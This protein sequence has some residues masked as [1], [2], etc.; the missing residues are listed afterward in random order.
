[1]TTTNK[2]SENTRRTLLKGL[3]ATSAV[4]AASPVLAGGGHVHHHIEKLNKPLIKIAN[5]CAQHGDECIDHC[6]ELFK[7]GDT[8]LAKCADAVNEMIVMCRALAKMA[9]YQSPE[10]KALAKICINVC[11]TC[12][13]ECNKHANK[14]ANCKACADSCLECIKECKKII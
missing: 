5:E 1:M 6:I 3:I 13:D 8:S 2:Q 9:T 14:H 11:Q 10:L 7:S 4:L 12:A